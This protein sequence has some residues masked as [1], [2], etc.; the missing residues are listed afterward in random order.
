MTATYDPALADDVSLV[1]FHIGDTNVS[2]PKLLDETISALLTQQGS[3]GKAV[4]AA[5]SY[6]MTLVSDPDFRAD[7]LQVTNSAAFAS[8]ER[9][10]RLKREEFGISAIT[11]SFI[12]VKRLD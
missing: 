9:L 5:I 11:A 2:A 7:W 3:V 4:I 12:A 6:L 1:R 8:L 10:M